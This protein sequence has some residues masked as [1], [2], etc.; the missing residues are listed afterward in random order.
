MAD[1]KVIK[2][3]VEAREA[4]VKGVNLLA[5]IVRATLG[6]KGRNAVLGSLKGPMITNDGVSIAHQ[7]HA[8][9]E[10]EE[11]GVLLIKEVARRTS[12]KAGD[13]TTTSTV[14]AQAIIKEGMDRLGQSQLTGPKVDAMQIKRDIEQ[15]CEKVVAEL[16]KVGKKIKTDEEIAWVATVAGESEEYGKKIADIFKEIGEHGMVR[17]EDSKGIEVEIETT[18][19]MTIEA[20]YAFPFSI[21]NEKLESV[22]KDA[23]IFITNHDIEKLEQLSPVFQEVGAR[24]KGA[25]VLIAES[26][27][28]PVVNALLKARQDGF[29]PLAIKAPYIRKDMVLKDIATV[30]GG[31]FIDKESMKLEDFRPDFLG[32]AEQVVADQKKT[33]FLGGAGKI[34]DAIKELEEQKRFVKSEF[35]KTKLDERVAQL[36]GAI[37]V[38]KVGAKSDPEQKY[39]RKKLDNAVNATKAAIEEG[40][41][42]GAGLT[43][44]K[45]AE[46]LPE[47]ILTNAIKAP[48]EQIQKNAGGK[49][50][51]GKDTI[52]P[53]KVTRIA[54]ENACSVAGVLLTTEAVVAE[55]N[56]DK[57]EDVLRKY[58]PQATPVE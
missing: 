8:E 35:E 50:E 58:L 54:L 53:V 39:L 11:Q 1:R 15:A 12:E 52:D 6:P 17:V 32:K 24:G 30:T 37:A 25:V 19:G 57:I 16:K 41:A 46:K 13:G 47:N 4:L 48:Y 22:S 40:V 20:G 44:K 49:H 42:P 9:D 7:V 14:L 26:F 2:T 45:I 3:G 31:T 36:R 55:R 5:D 34:E 21:T 43:L 27:S 29:I 38:I 18:T 51:I 33:L 23:N 28:I 10:I 56:E